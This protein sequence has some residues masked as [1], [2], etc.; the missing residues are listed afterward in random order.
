MVDIGTISS[1]LTLGENGIWYSN[2]VEDVSYPSE[3]SDN[4]YEIEENSFWFKH[5]NDCIA[6]VINAY[7]PEKNGTIFDI[8]GGNGY[9]SFGLE[10]LGYNV[11]LVEPGKVGASNAK[12]RGLANVVCA[13]TRTAK[14]YQQSLPAIGLFDVL[15][16]IEDDLG[17]L[18]SLRG[19]LKNNGH[20]YVTVPSYSAL[21]AAEDVWAGHFRRYDLMSMRRVLQLAGFQVEFSTYIF[22]FLPIPIFL[23]RSL[24][25][26]LGISKVER[27]SKNTSGDHTLK[28][29][30]VTT[31]LNVI[32][33]S[34]IK[35][36]NKGISMS[37][38]GSCLIV[39]KK[40]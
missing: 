5:R 4:C 30:V 32:L 29:G 10:G 16:H 7:P 37:F 6:S 9:V 25:Y 17:F 19:M 36:L 38:G 2:D 15:E 40:T 11:V 33:K 39:A 34:E 18:I 35:N 13:T 20:L 27:V 14:F 23:F 8:G 1:G 31:V 21:W 24:P 26:K 3:G 12:N 28:G 22:R